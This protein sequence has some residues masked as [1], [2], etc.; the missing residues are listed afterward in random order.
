MKPNLP[1]PK[2]AGHEWRIG[3]EKKFLCSKDNTSL[4]GLGFGSPLLHILTSN[5][6]LD[7]EGK[8]KRDKRSVKDDL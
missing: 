1:T 2:S 4:P 6:M 8:T 3:K 7:A 5:T